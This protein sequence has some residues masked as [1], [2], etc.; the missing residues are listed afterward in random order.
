MN[1]NDLVLLVRACLQNAGV[2]SNNR[3]KQLIAKG[4]P[5][6][7]IDHA[8]QIVQSALQDIDASPP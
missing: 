4:H 7:L 3:R 6:D 8:Q 5:G 2:L 1:N